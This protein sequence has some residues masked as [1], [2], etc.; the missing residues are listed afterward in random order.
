MLFEAA[1]NYEKARTND[2]SLP[3]LQEKIL[4]LYLQ[5]ADGF[6]NQKRYMEA[7]THYEK[8]IAITPN[9]P[10]IY[11]AIGKCYFERH[12][13]IKAIEYF[14]KTIALKGEFPDLE[15]QYK[16]VL[17]E[18]GEK[19]LKEHIFEKASKFFSRLIELY[20]KEPK[21]IFKL[22]FIFENILEYDKAIEQYQKVKSIDSNYLGL[23]INL[24]R[25]YM[26]KANDLFDKGKYEEACAQYK[27]ALDISPQSLEAIYQSGV[28]MEKTGKITEAYKFYEKVYKLDKDFKDI[29]EIMGRLIYTNINKFIEEK[30]YPEA[31]KE[32]TNL[33]QADPKNP[34]LH[35]I[36][37]SV[38]LSMND[39]DKA[40]IEYGQVLQINPEFPEI[41]DKLEQLYLSY[42]AEFMENKKFSE[43]KDYFEK[44]IALH[45]D[46]IIVNY[47]LASIYE[48]EGN[49]EKAAGFYD[50]VMELDKNYQNI[51]EK[52]CNIYVTAGGKFFD[53]KDFN[54]ASLYLEKAVKNG[55]ENEDILY[56]LGSAYENTGMLDKAKKYYDKIIKKEGVTY[57]DVSE[58][59]D[60]LDFHKLENNLE[61]EKYGEAIREAKKILEKNP[62]NI[63]IQY[64]LALSFEKKKFYNEAVQYFDD[65]LKKQSDYLDV[66]ERMKKIY[67]E[68]ADKIFEMGSY[69]DALRD[70][71]ESIKF[72]NSNNDDI[73]FKIAICYF[74]MGEYDKAMEIIRRFVLKDSN[75]KLNHNL[76]GQ[77]YT[78]KNM[79]DEAVSE[80]QKA[81]SI[82]KNFAEAYNNLGMVYIKKGMYQDA[83]KE[84]KTA[85]K[86]DP[87]IE[88]KFNG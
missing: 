85:V 58:K 40:R 44:I 86:I 19:Y 52:I 30:K 50:K 8:V 23:L 36:M 13:P 61:E 88:I 11:Y 32:C 41:N 27:N 5:I 38:Y 9:R 56:K 74:N 77:I 59:L 2:N 69:S 76:L 63:E 34:R 80:F 73:N 71:L 26:S 22:G 54:N 72:D 4:A 3:G 67:I 62:N 60:D 64:N 46:S 6:F 10:E 15:K 84:F 57:K 48:N 24:E 37:A 78:Q 75:N 16:E 33:L 66:K 20:P 49:I 18:L 29:N 35:F 39:K 31:I 81:I 70:Y 17:E 68:K 55:F 87:S 14:E 51:S 65:I 28:I 21:F 42:A 25:T 7:I 83:M 1:E 53:K 43:A 47:N 82:D 79:L 45:P 12:I